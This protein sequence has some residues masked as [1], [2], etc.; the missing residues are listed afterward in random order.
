MLWELN[1]VLVAP[2]GLVKH[3]PDITITMT[4]YFKFYFSVLFSHLFDHFGNTR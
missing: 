3:G 2:V 4:A 1:S